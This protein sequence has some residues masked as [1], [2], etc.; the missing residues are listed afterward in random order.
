[1]KQT[2]KEFCTWLI[3]LEAGIT[4]MRV[5]IW[6][7]VQWKDDSSGRMREVVVLDQRRTQA[8]Y[9]KKKISNEKV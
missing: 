1:M 3:D 6:E 8:K 4:G 9:K 2:L 5:G 7:S